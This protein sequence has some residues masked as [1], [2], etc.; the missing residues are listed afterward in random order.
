MNTLKQYE[1]DKAKT[2]LLKK[3]L[4]KELHVRQENDLKL[5]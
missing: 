4:V 5:V 2:F 3:D 1:I